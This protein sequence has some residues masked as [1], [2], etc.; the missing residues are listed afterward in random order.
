MTSNIT[1]YSGPTATLVVPE[2]TP[3]LVNNPGPNTVYLGDNNAIRATDSFGVIPLAANGY[4]NVDGSAD[5]YAITSPGQTQTVNVLG[6]GIN[7]FSPPSLAGLGGAAIYVQATAPTAPIPLH[8]LWFNTTAPVSLNYWNGSSWV[9]QAFAAN[10]LISAGTIVANLM[11]SGIVVAGI[12]DATTIT[13]PTINGGVITGAQLIADGSSGEFLVYSSAPPA[14]GNLIGSWSGTAGSDTPGNSFPAGLAIELGGLV[15]F[16]QSSA[17]SAVSGASILY[18]SSLGRLRYLSA[19]GADMILDR[20]NLNIGNFTMNT[21]T[22]PQVMSG[23]I[24]YLAN[25]ALTGSEYEIQIDGTFTSPNTTS[26]TFTFDLFVDGA[27][28][29]IGSAITVG[30]VVVSTGVTYA[31]SVRFRLTVN[32]PGA[33]G[34][35]MVICDG[36]VT[37]KGVNAGN[38]STFATLNNVV[39]NGTLDTTSNHTFA[40]Y[41]NWGSTT[42]TGHSAITYRTRI[43]RRN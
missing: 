31:Y 20:S 33:F 16:S 5:L 30:T 21:Q 38:T 24:N 37:R 23:A 26:A 8:S 2:G 36:S 12:V 43:I 25:E 34:T 15:L 35:V 10:Q 28:L 27:S 14:L 42:G 17:V 7:F 13:A 18:T 40:I 11:A 41:C 32:S 9:V 22:L 29:G 19:A 3:A 1:V 39:V 4:V 6:G